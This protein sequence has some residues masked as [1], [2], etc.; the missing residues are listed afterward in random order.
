MLHSINQ[1]FPIHDIYVKMMCT[2]NKITVK[3]GYQI[4]ITLFLSLSKGIW[5]D[6]ECVG[7][8]IL[9][10]STIWNLCNGVKGCKRTVDIPSMHWICSRS[11]WLTGFTSIRS[12]PCFLAVHNVACNGQSGQSVNTVAVQRVFFELC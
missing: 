10:Y 4:S 5:H 7:N 1:N 6:G 8:A 9:T 12:S 2:L 11:K 3:N